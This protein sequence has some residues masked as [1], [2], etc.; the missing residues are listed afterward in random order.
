MVGYGT[1]GTFGFVEVLLELEG[2]FG[3]WPEGEGGEDG[4]CDGVE[5]R[6]HCVLLV[7]KWDLGGSLLGW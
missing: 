6:W 7:Q 1:L 2:G 4:G 3:G 5:G